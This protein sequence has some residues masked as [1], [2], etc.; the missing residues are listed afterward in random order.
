MA[1]VFV[2]LVF[3]AS[4]PPV[5]ASGVT[6][7]PHCGET[8]MQSTA[9]TSDIGPCPGDGLVIGAD[10]VTLDL[11]G[12]S[13]EGSGGGVGVSVGGDL[14]ARTGV[15]VR[16]G[17]IAQFDQGVLLGGNP[18]APSSGNSAVLLTLIDDQSGVR[19]QYGGSN[20]IAFDHGSGT[21]AR[22]FIE[23]F[24]STANE[25]AFDTSSDG[26][27][28]AASGPYEL[29]G[30]PSSRNRIEHNQV[31]SIELGSSARTTV[32]NNR[33]MSISAHPDYIYGANSDVIRHNTV[34]GGNIS[35]DAASNTLVFRNRILGSPSNGIDLTEN[36]SCC[37]G[38]VSF[39]TD[40]NTL[41]ANRI[42]GSHGDGIFLQ[43]P[44]Q[45]IPNLIVEPDSKGATNTLVRGNVTSHNGGDGVHTDATTTTLTRNTANF[46]IGVGINAPA[47]AIDGGGNRAANNGVAQCVNIVCWK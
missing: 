26:M 1:S 18:T 27:V 20:L 21:S 29:N 32:A 38:V 12:H 13:I 25:V 6:N 22:A 44:H 17:T 4:R 19:A 33:V 8:I 41:L 31:T 40:K 9:L 34:I 36:E 14:T 45:V 15:T 39:A 10:N 35:L 11:N 37:L 28:V 16:N 30:T 3:A 47:G 7:D 24:S 46:N 42:L 23:L 2:C 5:S 43:A